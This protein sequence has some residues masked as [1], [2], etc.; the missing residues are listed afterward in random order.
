MTSKVSG[1]H[2][3]WLTKYISRWLDIFPLTLNQLLKVKTNKVIFDN[4][5]HSVVWPFIIFKLGQAAFAFC[6]SFDQH[7]HTSRLDSRC[8]NFCCFLSW[9]LF[10]FWQR[11]EKKYNLE[12]SKGAVSKDTKFEYAWCL[13]R[14]KYSNDIK[15]GIVLLEGESI[16][17]YCNLLLVYSMTPQ[18]YV[19][20]LLVGWGS[21]TDIVI[22]KHTFFLT[23]YQVILSLLC[24]IK[25]L[26]HHCMNSLTVQSWYRRVQRMTRG[27][28]C[29]IWLL[30]TT[31]LR[32]G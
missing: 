7:N 16:Q 26:Q 24:V 15:K 3:Y 9:C 32:W 22:K 30:Q 23:A 18:Y 11:F 31:N 12:V 8:Y 4:P 5:H 19:K 28:I 29:F 21:M 6:Y 17:S 13:T 10:V 27:T 1:L 20:L 14:S 25:L 2:I